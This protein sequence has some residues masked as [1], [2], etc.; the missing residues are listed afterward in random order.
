MQETRTKIS[1]KK[2]YADQTGLLIIW[3]DA[4][5]RQCSGVPG[6]SLIKDDEELIV[7]GDSVVEKTC[8][9]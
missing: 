5:N 1:P 8:V 7:L 9:D 4:N 3:F 6:S 2:K